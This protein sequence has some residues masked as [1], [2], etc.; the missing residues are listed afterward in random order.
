MPRKARSALHASRPSH[1][2]WPLLQ[3]IEVVHHTII[4]LVL[5]LPIH[6]HKLFIFEI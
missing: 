6:H 1:L 5:L 4:T 2:L 3:R